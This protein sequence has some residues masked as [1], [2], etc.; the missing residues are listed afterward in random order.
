MENKSNKKVVIAACVLVAIVAVLAIAYFA[1]GPK[2]QSGSKAITIQVTNKAEETT[3]Y[4]FKTDAEFLQ[5]AMDEAKDL[6]YNEEGG[7][8]DTINGE[9]ADWNVDQSYWAIYVNGEYG[10]FGIA[11]QPVADGDVFLFQYTVGF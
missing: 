3:D 5:Q 10:M 8:V 7:F 4:T 1:F 6:T 9:K 11:D 2:A